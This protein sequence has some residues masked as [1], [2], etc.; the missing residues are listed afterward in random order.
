MA[1]LNADGTQ[2]NGNGGPW[3]AKVMTFIER[4][5]VPAALLGFLIWNIVGSQAKDV[6]ASATTTALMRAELATHHT[7]TESLHRNIED[8]MRVQTL[9]TRQLCVNSARTP[10]DRAECFKL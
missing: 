1:L 6:A 8:Y 10:Q 4:V 9:L 3:Q 5:G 7:H 2:T